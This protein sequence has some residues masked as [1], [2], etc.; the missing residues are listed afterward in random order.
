MSTPL[1]PEVTKYFW[2][3]NLAELNWPQHKQYIVQTLLDKGDVAAIRWL[4]QQVERTELKQLLPTVQLGK[5]SENF[6]RVYLQ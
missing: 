5:R 6:W 2:G 3:D 4:F 1:P